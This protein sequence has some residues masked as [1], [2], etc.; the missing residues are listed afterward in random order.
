MSKLTPAE[1]AELDQLRAGADSELDDKVTIVR[2]LIAAYGEVTAT[3]ILNE[4]V[5][6]SSDALIRGGFVLALIRLATQ[7]RQGPG[8]E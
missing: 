7:D 2:D 4:L 3:G 1:L 8:R 6:K 5:R